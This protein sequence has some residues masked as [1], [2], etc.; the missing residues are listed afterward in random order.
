MYS[1][2][3]RLIR[4]YATEKK[5]NSLKNSWISKVTFLEEPSL[6]TQDLLTESCNMFFCMRAC[7]KQLH[8]PWS[9]SG[10]PYFASN[11]PKPNACKRLRL[12]LSSASS[13][14]RRHA[15]FAADCNSVLHSMH[16]S[17]KLMLRNVRSVGVWRIAIRADESAKHFS[18]SQMATCDK[19]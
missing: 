13:L 7:K 4:Q 15:L 19:P 8:A 11:S 10:G 14:C 17:H 5:Y 1:L 12:S 2:N 3:S 16:G 6:N 9:I 18:Q